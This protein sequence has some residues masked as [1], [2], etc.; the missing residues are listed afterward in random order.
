MKVA[1]LGCGPTG[2]IAAHACLTHGIYP[3]VF[4]RK[5]KSALYGS[6]YL[7]EPIPGIDHGEE[8]WVT[9]INKGTPEEYRRK[10]HG[11]FWDGI[12]APADFETAHPAWDI[13]R[14]YNILWRKYHDL[15]QDYVIPSREAPKIPGDGYAHPYWT[16]NKDLNIDSYDLVIS[17]VPRRIWAIEGEQYIYSLGWAV[18]DAPER[19]QFVNLEVPDMTIICDGSPDVAYN[20]LSHVFGYKTVEW[21]AHCIGRDVSVGIPASKLIKPL[22]YVPA[23]FDINPVNGTRW[24]H[25]GRFGKWQKGVVVTDAWHEVQAELR[26]RLGIT[27]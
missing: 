4:S 1:I 25:V 7:H 20:R 14:A 24:L 2:M 12:I 26:L 21:P 15:V 5:I 18:G 9:Y 17:T 3:Q 13:R 19:G 23:E 10:T 11:K 16:L 27:V 8:E 22:K 6:Q